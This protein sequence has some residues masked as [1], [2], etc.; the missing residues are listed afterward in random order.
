[1]NILVLGGT[2][3]MGTHSVDFLF[4]NNDVCV[5]VTYRK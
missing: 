4:E 3:A 1:M 2:V 5:I